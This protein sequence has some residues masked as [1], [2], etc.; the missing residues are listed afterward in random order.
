M[1]E[2]FVSQAPSEERLPVPRRPRIDVPWGPRQVVW[3]AVGLAV[4][5]AIAAG[6]FILLSLLS[7]APRTPGW[8]VAVATF[9]LQA[10]IIAIAFRLGPYRRGGLPFVLLG[11]RRL[12]TPALFGWGALALFA[13]VAAISAYAATAGQLSES[14]V[15]PPL[16]ERL[17]MSELRVLMFASIVIA[18]PMAEE[19]FFRGFLFAGL[20]RRFGLWPAAAV[21]AALFAATHIDVALLGPAFLAGIV[22]AIVYWRTGSVWPTILAH[23]AQNAIAF[24]LAA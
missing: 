21:S 6:V 4:V 23:T 20:L 24:G 16:S 19:T 18:A 17:D 3:G 13:S 5:G 15:P 14:L 2:P 7:D 1:D 10:G 11:V 9:V 12:A 22:F 8:I